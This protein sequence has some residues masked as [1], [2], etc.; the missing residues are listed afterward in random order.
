MK[1]PC[2]SAP[3]WIEGDRLKALQS[4]GILDTEIEKDFE[5]I[6]KMASEICNVP[7]S[8]I[9]FVASGRQWFKAAFGTTL[10]ETALDVSICSYA[11]QQE[12]LF[13]VPDTT[14]DQRFASNPLVS[15]EPHLR[16]YA[17]ALL[18]SPEGLPIGTVCILDYKPRTLTER[19]SNSLK[20]LA[21][22]VM[23]L[24]ELRRALN[25]KSQ[26]EERLNLAL[27]ASGF[28]GVWEWDVI[29][30]RVYADSRFLAAFGGETSWS[31]EG[32]PMSEYVK[33][34]HPQDALRV[35]GAIQRALRPGETFK[36]EYRLTRKNGP[37]L[38]IEAR[39]R[40]HFDEAGKP[41]RLPGVAV[42]ITER[43]QAQAR[44]EFL[45]GLTEKL[46]LLSGPDELNRVATR[47]VGQFLGGNRCYFFEAIPPDLCCHV[48][49]DWHVPEIKSL[50]GTYDLAVFGELQMWETLRFTSVCIDD[51]GDHPWTKRFADNY[52]AMD[53][54]SAW[55]A[56][57]CRDG[58][59]VACLGVSSDKPRRWTPEDR[60][61]LENVMLRVWPL[62]ERARM[63]LELHESERNFRAMSDNIAPLAWM[64][65][66]DGVVF[67]YNKRWYD[68]TGATPETMQKN[69]WNNVHDPEHR[70][71]VE[72]TWESAVQHEH[73]WEDTFPLLGA[74]GKFRWFLS[75][76]FPIRGVDGKISR[77]FGVNTDI[78]ELRDAQNALKDANAL[79][80]NKAVHLESLVQ[81]RTKNLSETIAE[82]EA[83][84]YSISHDM[85]APL[86]S[87]IHYAE[88]LKED[89]GPTISAMG[90]DYLDRISQAS[91]RMDQLIQDVLVLSRLSREEISLV[92][93]DIDALMREIIQTYPNLHS[94]KVTISIDSALPAVM[95]NA[96][97]LTQCFSNLLDNAAK[98]AK[99]GTVARVHVAAE[100]IGDRIKIFFR[101][102][103]IGIPEHSLKKIFEIFQRVGRDAA[104][105]GIGLSIVRKAVEKMEGA[106]G[107]NSELG[108]GSLFWLDLKAA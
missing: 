97:F 95:G 62:I 29:K 40:C 24:L 72:K 63:E 30:D 51:S 33:A 99:P 54:S 73:P 108:H 41:V 79:L 67:W 65:K 52:R 98:F 59:W 42:D 76:A 23:T 20:S 90:I 86:R 8:L 9:S 104:G 60:A 46:S 10:K 75:R 106:V 50:Q 6:V 19:E 61:F 37:P 16:F 25:A 89:C 96:A 1:Q 38:W 4:Y 58:K 45:S 102:D 39:G 94:D 87:M 47:E 28:I 12:N 48:T 7:L 103:G 56:P 66:A 70:A 53:I 74:D 36:Q 11:I 5:D 88:M 2:A 26:S 93:V 15:G 34:I 17:G 92:S 18:Q 107:V 31:T 84:S 27:E 13:I 105:T 21:R 71:R 81:Q 77:W 49:P 55:I 83:F 78:T 64:A 68:Y 3:A 57:F 100:K 14:K 85:R 69:G 44:T 43:R 35:V 32:V 82:L 22:Q 101:D 80:G 91:L